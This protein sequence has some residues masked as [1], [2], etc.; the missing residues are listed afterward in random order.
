[1]PRERALFLVRILTGSTFLWCGIYFKVLQPNLVLA[2]ITEGGVPT[3]GLP[4]EA[5]VFGMALVEVS[6]G[7]LMMAGVRFSRWHSPYLFPS[8]SPRRSGRPP[9]PRAVLW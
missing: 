6:A 7:A 8:F 2:I 1:M 4:P 5:F 3:F 9:R